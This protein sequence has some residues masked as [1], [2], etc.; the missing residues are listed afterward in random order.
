MT[1]LFKKIDK[2]FQEKA[3]FY[4]SDEFVIGELKSAPIIIISATR[5]LEKKT[6]FK[7]NKKKDLKLAVDLFVKKSSP[8]KSYHS[9]VDF[10]K[11]SDGYFVVVYYVAEN[12][13]Q[14][15]KA[16]QTKGGIILPEQA[17]VR[18]S[19]ELACTI[20]GHGSYI[21]DPNYKMQFN[22]PK[23]NLLQKLVEHQGETQELSNFVAKLFNSLNASKILPYWE[24]I[25]LGDKAEFNFTL[26]HL[27]S[28]FS[29]PLFYLSLTSA[30]LYSDHNKAL[31]TYEE[32]KEKI[33]EYKALERNFEE[34]QS[35]LSQLRKP[36]KNY[37]YPYKIFDVMN[38]IDVFVSVQSFSINSTEI[39]INGISDDA[40]LVFKKL[41]EDKRLKD[42]R[43]VRPV[44]KSGKRESFTIGFKLEN[45]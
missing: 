32:N 1:N 24:N 16:H 7:I 10:F 20:N 5:V 25:H 29:L 4:A 15:L 44:R 36:F 28:V 41:S 27:V 2:I 33:S 43:Y 17:L 8:F 14:N 9:W 13:Y 45:S 6:F 21:A 37:L 12:V 22:L 30:W 42:L 35:E 26:G 11:A 19:P 40:S 34:M 39:S 3:A 31:K 18:K 23:A 38:Q